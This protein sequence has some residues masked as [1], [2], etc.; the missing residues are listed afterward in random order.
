MKKL[1]S[2]TVILIGILISRVR[3]IIGTIVAPCVVLVP[4]LFSFDAP[5]AWAEESEEKVAVAVERTVRGEY[6][7]AVL[8]DGSDCG[9]AQWILSLQADG[10]RILRAYHYVTATGVQNSTVSR[11]DENFHPEEGFI[12]L[13]RDGESYGSAFFL[14]K[15]STLS[16]TVN[17]PD[18]HYA[19]N[20]D[21]PDEFHLLL[22]PITAY[23][24]LMAN[25]DHEAGG[26]QPV[27]LCAV[28]PAGRGP[29]CSIDVRDIEFL[30]KETITVPAG[31][32]DADHYKVGS[33]G[34]TWIVGPDHMVVQHQHSRRNLQF[35]LVEYEIE[36]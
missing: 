16:M 32:F 22:Y 36:P 6:S 2:T 27:N 28:A 33:S 24:W 1:K 14:V 34:D 26:P 25:Y 15:G 18:E 23:G 17:T 11:V 19:E 21:V 30:G 13:Y 12:N 10:S 9:D 35:K 7:C 20:L 5:N 8:D 31:T 29:S 3:R 4:M